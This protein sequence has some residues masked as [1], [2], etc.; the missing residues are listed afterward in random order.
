MRAVPREGLG[1][2]LALL[3]A[4]LPVTS[5]HRHL[6]D[7]QHTPVGSTLET[8]SFSVF[9]QKHSLPPTVSITPK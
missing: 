9:A 1:L 8:C 6:C 5:Q 7:P 3:E 4:R 2:C